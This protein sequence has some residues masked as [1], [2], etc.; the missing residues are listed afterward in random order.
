[1]GAKKDKLIAYQKMAL[2]DEYMARLN[3]YQEATRRATNEVNKLAESQFGS[4]LAQLALIK[5]YRV[6]GHVCISKSTS[7]KCCLMCY[8]LLIS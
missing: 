3:D 5:G 6:D 2:L 8:S 1:M 7:S 4:L